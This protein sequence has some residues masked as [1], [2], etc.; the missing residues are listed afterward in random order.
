MKFRNWS[1]PE[2]ECEQLSEFFDAKR[3]GSCRNELK[4]PMGE[5]PVCLID[6]SQRALICLV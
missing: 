6:I 3:A 4:Q 5:L 2:I 1:G